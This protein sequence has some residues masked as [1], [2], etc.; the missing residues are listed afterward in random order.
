MMDRSHE[1]FGD[2]IDLFHSTVEQDMIQRLSDHFKLKSI[3]R[4]TVFCEYFGP[5]SFA[6]NHESTDPKTLKMF[7]VAI[8]KKGFIAPKQFIDIFTG[9]T[10]MPGIAYHGNLN[11]IFVEQVRNDTEQFDEGVVCKA[12][13]K[14]RV[15]MTKIKTKHWLE[16][17]KEKFPKEW[18]KFV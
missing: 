8:Y 10:Y 3:E 18:E 14:D 2:S 4:I 16:R 9:A 7:D 1:Q 17:L 15:L 6:G 13:V 5:H 11:N 12:Q